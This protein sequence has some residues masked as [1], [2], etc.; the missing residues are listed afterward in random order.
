[1]ERKSDIQPEFFLDLSSELA[2]ASIM[3]SLLSVLFI[4]SDAQRGQR[5]VLFVAEQICR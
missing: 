3:L 2:T 5:L 4:G 1:M